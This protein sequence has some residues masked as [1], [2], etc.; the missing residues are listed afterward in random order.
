MLRT[1]NKAISWA[2][3]RTPPF[4]SRRV[5]MQPLLGLVSSGP[6]VPS[7]PG[8]SRQPA[9]SD[10]WLEQ[11]FPHQERSKAL[12]LPRQSQTELDFLLLTPLSTPDICSRYSRTGPVGP[13][14]PHYPPLHSM[15]LVCPIT[16]MHQGMTGVHC[17]MSSLCF[18]GPKGDNEAEDI[19]EA[20]KLHGT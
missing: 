16:A 14:S 1:Q 19:G 11:G 17:L 4:Y 2:F 9:V 13:T 3:S 12:V 5:R 18:P 10:S 7:T 8:S 15:A 20:L 6:V